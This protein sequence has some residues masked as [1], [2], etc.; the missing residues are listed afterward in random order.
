MRRYT[1]TMIDIDED[2]F[3]EPELTEQEAIRHQVMEAT[4]DGV[5][6]LDIVSK[7]GE[8]CTVRWNG[9]RPVYDPLQDDIEFVER[10]I[11]NA[12]RVTMPEI[13]DG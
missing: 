13:E 5:G 8:L 7:D 10:Y 4:E 1:L 12:D 6:G 11:C 2:A 9:D 3:V